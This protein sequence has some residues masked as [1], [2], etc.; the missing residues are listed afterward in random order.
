M[1]QKKIAAVG[2]WCVA[3]GNCANYCPIQAIAVRRGVRAVVDD[4]KCVGC[5]RCEKAC[6]ASIITIVKRDEHA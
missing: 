5:G 2:S 6:P 1:I 4:A 3:C